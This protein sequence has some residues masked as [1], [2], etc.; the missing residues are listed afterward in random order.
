MAGAWPGLH[1]ARQDGGHG[2][3]VGAPNPRIAAHR[4]PAPHLILLGLPGPN[5]VMG[6]GTWQGW[7]SRVREVV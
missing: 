2:Y 7:G 6:R 3:R 5:Q 4:P 1:W